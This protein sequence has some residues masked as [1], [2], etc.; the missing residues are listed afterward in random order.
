MMTRK[1]KGFTLIELLVVIAIIGI[2]AAMVFPVFARARESAR[3]AVCL[4]N[5]KNIALAI[6]MYLADNNDT[7]MPAQEQRQEV[8]EYFQALDPD[9]ERMGQA[10]PYLRAPVILDEYIK[11]RDVWRCPSA[12]VLNGATGIIPVQDWFGFLVA[13]AGQWG[14]DGGSL[15]PC[16]FI[17]PSGWGGDVTDSIAQ[18]R[19]ASPAFGSGDQAAHKTFVQSIGVNN[20]WNN[21]G[22]KLVEVQD[23]CNFFICGDGGVH[24]DHLDSV[25][26]VAYPGLCAL[27]CSGQDW[28]WADWELC[29]ETAADCG[30]Y[31]YAPN[32][33]SFLRNQELLKP[34]TR[35]LGGSNL[36]FLDGHAQWMNSRALINKVGEGDLDGLT[37]WCPTSVLGVPSWSTDPDCLQDPA[38]Y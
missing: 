26:H 35:H 22:M 37:F 5:V 19:S 36:G 7:L 33:G 18:N 6:Q 4:S 29:A 32:D 17:Y 30:L 8:V 38:I 16:S 1:R 12:K 27:E 10:N 24:V 23:P 13:H 15:L 9:C 14:P 34:Y 20:N 25:S 21:G 2:L 28:A 11:N 31:N 3:K